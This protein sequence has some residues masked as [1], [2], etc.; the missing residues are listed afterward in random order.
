M[1]I[2]PKAMCE[3]DTQ[4]GT[5]RFW[6]WSFLG[7]N[8]A[9]GDLVRPLGAD[10]DVA[11]V[12]HVTFGRHVPLHV[13]R[14]HRV[15]AHADRL[16]RRPPFQQFV[17][18]HHVP[19]DH[20]PRFADVDLVRPVAV[21]DELVPGEA[22]LAHRRPHVFRHARIVGDEVHQSLLVDLVFVDDLAAA[23][24]GGLGVVVVAADVVGAERTVVVRVGLAIRDR[25]RT[26]RTSRAS[27]PGRSAAAVRTAARRSPR[28]WGTA[29]GSSGSSVRHMR[30]Q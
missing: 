15:R 26:C 7:L 30:K 22:P 10:T 28:A 2:D 5:S 20:P 11:F 1:R 12:L 16:G 19:A 17:L 6:H 18:G 13:V 4:T 24:V 21:V 29:R 8:R 25:S 23:L 3:L 14:V 27:P 9:E